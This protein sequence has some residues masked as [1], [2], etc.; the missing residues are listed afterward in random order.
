LIPAQRGYPN[1]IEQHRP[2][3][4]AKPNHDHDLCR[5]GTLARLPA[6]MRRAGGRTSPELGEH[7]YDEVTER[8][9]NVIEL[10]MTRLHEK[11][12]LRGDFKPFE[13]LPGRGYMVDI[14]PSSQQPRAEGTN[15]RS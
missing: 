7:L 9:G 4:P 13:T 1:A 10:Y 3:D 2:A 8:N 6:L 5:Q 14:Q 15:R 11:L 12:D